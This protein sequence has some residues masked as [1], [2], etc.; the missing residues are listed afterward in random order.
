MQMQFHEHILTRLLPVECSFQRSK[1]LSLLKAWCVIA[2]ALA[3]VM[4]IDQ[5]LAA[6]DMYRVGIRIGLVVAIACIGAVLL[7][8]VNLSRHADLLT[9]V[10]GAEVPPAVPPASEQLLRDVSL[11]VEHIESIR[12][13]LEISNTHNQ[14]IPRAV[15]ANLNLVLKNLENARTRFSVRPETAHS[16]VHAS[17]VGEDK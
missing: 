5:W 10:D 7:C 3:S 15:P 9:Q 4:I 6:P 16:P 12:I 2:A 1:A 17:L 8:R 14:P 11:A 13:L